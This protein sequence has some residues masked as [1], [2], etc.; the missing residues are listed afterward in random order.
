MNVYKQRNYQNNVILMTYILRDLH[1]E[2]VC[3]KTDKSRWNLVSQDI[4]LSSNPKLK[5][6]N[7][8]TVKCYA[9]Y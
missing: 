1:R 6:V 8:H 4:I 3:D 7:P 5:V 2:I 9:T